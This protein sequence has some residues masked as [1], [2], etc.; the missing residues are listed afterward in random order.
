MTL[1]DQRI[2][3]HY[4]SHIF[5]AYARLDLPTFEDPMVQRQLE[6]AAGG[7]T[8]VAWDT[9]QMLSN[10]F[11]HLIRLVSEVTVLINVLR[12]QRDGTLIALLSFIP[13][14]L[15]WLRIQQYAPRGGR[16]LLLFKYHYSIFQK[17]WAAT[18]RNKA[19][20]KLQGLKRMVTSPI[21]RK[22]IVAG[23]LFERLMKGA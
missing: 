5:E 3:A 1:L 12:D 17:V 14:C 10:T 8:S 21:H 6:A 19:Y 4:S 7:R 15:Q 11:S 20:M 22:E 23:N 9:V 16:L 18:C 13:P 2:K